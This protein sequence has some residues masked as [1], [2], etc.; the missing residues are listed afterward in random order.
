[1][2]QTRSAICGVDLGSGKQLW[3]QDIPTFR[4]MNIITP[5]VYE[6][7]NLLTSSYGGTTQLINVS[8][9]GSSMQMKQKWNLPAQGYMTTPIVIGG[10]AYTHLRNQRFACY[11]LKNGVEKWRSKPFGK[12]ASLI[13]SG[14]KILALIN[15]AS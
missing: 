8:D 13:A 12:Y 2:V 1:M 7:D 6:G 3:S 15:A 14:D 5:V 9:A 11:D 10:H 4:G